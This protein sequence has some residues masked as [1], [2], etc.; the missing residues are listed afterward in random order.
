MLPPQWQ[1]HS[2]LDCFGL[3]W[4]DLDGVPTTWKEA[5]ILEMDGRVVHKANNDD[6]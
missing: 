2:E 1:N 5:A 6:S 3:L 4:I